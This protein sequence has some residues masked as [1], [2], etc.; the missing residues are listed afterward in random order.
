MRLY[1][2]YLLER[3]DAHLMSNSYCF[4]SYK[5]IENE[6]IIR[7]IFCDPKHRHKGYVN[8]FLLE[9]ETLAKSR[10]CEYLTGT[11]W[12]GDPN[13]TYNLGYAFRFGFK[14]SRTT[15]EMTVVAKIL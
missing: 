9:I 2:K 8:K 6:C 13:A 4:V 7:D 15:P 5:F 12:S 3:E 11:V 10:G 14:L 1:E